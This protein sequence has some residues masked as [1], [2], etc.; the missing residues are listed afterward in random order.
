L[1]ASDMTVNS[2]SLL[3]VAVVA[4]LPHDRRPTEEEVMTRAA[5]LRLA[6]PV[7]DQEF[8][9]LIKRLHARLAITMDLGTALVEQ[10]HVPWLAG[11]KASID[12]FY[13]ERFRLWLGTEDWQPLV[14]NGIDA[15][16]D[17]I[18]DYAGDPVREGS[19]ARRGLV[20]G[21]VQSGKTA[22]YTA[23]ACKAADAGYHLVILLTGTLESLRRQTQERMDEG[24]VGLD[25]SDILQQPQIRTSRA[26]GVGL[27]DTRRAAGVFTS[28]SRDFSRQLMTQ[29][30]FRLDAFQEPVLVVL[31]K[32]RRILDN[33]ENWLRS[34][35]ALDGR[36]SAPLLLIDDEAD[37]ASINTNPENADPTRINAG[38]RSLL[39]L[40]QRSSYVGVTATPFAN[41]FIDP[42]S[43]SDMLGDDLFPSDFIYSLEPP[44]NYIGPEAVFGRGSLE[45]PHPM[46]RWND[47]ADEYFPPGH[48]AG[49]RVDALP[50]SLLEAVR[51]F[52]VA[53][54]IRDIR[55]EGKTHR[56]MLVN[57]SR[58]TAVQDQVAG[59]V[60]NYVRDI[61]RDVRNF[62][63]L[64]PADALAVPNI[65]ALHDTW[66]A[67]FTS[68]GP[69][70][71]AMQAAMHEA[72]QPIVV[73][74][75]N[76]R[77]GAASLD[78]KAHKDQGL[79]VIAVGG[80]SLSRGLTLEGLSTSY[81]RRNSQMYDTLLQMGRWFGYRKGYADLCRLWLGEEAFTWYSHITRASAELR[82]EFK[83]MK[84]LNLT[85][86]DFGLKVR[87]HP[88]ALIIT[89]R[90]KMRTANTVVREV[91]LSGES[92]ETTRL[93]TSAQ[94]IRANEAAAARFVEALRSV[95]PGEAS[96]RG[97]IWHNVPRAQI[98][99][100]L[101]SFTT[102]AL[103]Y[104]FQA[105]RLSD[106]LE[107]TAEPC[108]E[109]WDVSIPSGSR[110]PEQLGGQVVRP[111]KRHVAVNAAN[112]SLLV[113]GSSSLVGSPDDEREG[114]TDEQLKQAAE[115][116]DG[117]PTRGDY[118]AARTSP[119]L[120]LHTLRGFTRVPGEKSASTPYQPGL[121]VLVALGLIFPVFDDSDVRERVEFKV[122]LVEWR[123]LVAP[124]IE[125]DEVDDDDLD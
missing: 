112:G 34:Y 111:Y 75:V 123:S 102:H 120:L 9:H 92:I 88:D 90:N 105:D 56:S 20:V 39:S 10:R 40:F 100:F 64:P 110:D 13:W 58:F 53:T 41:V 55:G 101:A 108:L 15:V 8:D 91:S 76:Q 107:R 5:E 118:R 79:R 66:R 67:E 44:S 48:M 62:S 78:Y 98:A 116:S 68:D 36:I 77:T 33:L 73:R 45:S 95:D 63:Q 113:S 30:G 109:A 52:I 80:N 104:D 114:L 26:V 115:Q 22:T 94:V 119:L 89:A 83:R 23:L 43:G 42:D 37:S 60:D 6:F 65:A 46:I 2:S 47:D 19:W 12:P 74:A 17:E 70:W 54:T 72:V 27:I 93:S 121:P 4:T 124:E 81:F 49:F 61:Q 86:N 59:A 18:L 21:D 82:L 24:F 96:V 87:A 97:W 57:V 51:Q 1:K 16:T 122:N 69:S 31:K 106:F 25:S 7:D 84:R 32:N 117:K 38:V 28:H 14:I 50:P 85:P 125:D 103:N 3:E 29:L 99:A 35:N 11:R 71:V